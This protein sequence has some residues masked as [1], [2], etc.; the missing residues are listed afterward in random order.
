MKKAVVLLVALMLTFSGLALADEKKVDGKVTAV[1]GD[2]VTIEV[3]AGK[4][5][6][7]AVGSAVEVKVQQQKEEKKAAPKKGKDMLQGC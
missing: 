1:A 5:A 3:E 4:G 7:V 6:D 2:V